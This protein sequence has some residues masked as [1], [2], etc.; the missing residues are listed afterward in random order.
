MYTCHKLSKFLGISALLFGIASSAQAIAYSDVVDCANG[1]CAYPNV[2]RLSGITPIGK[3]KGTCTGSMLQSATPEKPYFIFL[4]A[5]HC[6]AGWHEHAKDIESP[7]IKLGV[8]GDLITRSEESFFVTGGIPVK[9]PFYS[10]GKNEKSFMPKYDQGVVVFPANAQ[11]L[12]GRTID[13]RWPGIITP[14]ILPQDVGFSLTSLNRDDYF[15]NVGYGIGELLQFG[16]GNAGGLE[17]G[18]EIFGTRHIAF[19]AAFLALTPANMTTSQNPA[20]GDDGA[21]N[22]DSGGP[23]FYTLPTGQEIVVGLVNS[24]DYVC[25]ATNVVSRLDVPEA[26]GFISC[27]RNANS[28]NEVKACGITTGDFN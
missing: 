15:K 2:V 10:A 9:S 5:G 7:I 14:V 8:S 24:G 17:S 25:R 21:C 1:T 26:Q 23:N 11:D 27:V 12:N 18:L 4:T 6:A 20:K 28:I 22:G 16:G 3:T 13:A 19:H